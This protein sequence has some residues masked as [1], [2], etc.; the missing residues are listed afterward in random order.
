M[1]ERHGLSLLRCAWPGVEAV[2]ADTAHAFGRH[3]HDQFGIGL[4]ERGAQQSASGRGKVEALAGDLITVN[5]GEVHDGHPLDASG[6]AWRMLYLDPAVLAPLTQDL[7]PHCSFEFSA[8]VL[9]DTRL[10]AGFRA[11]FQTATAS[12]DALRFES[13]LLTLLTGLQAPAERSPM[14]V[15]GGVRRV[16]Q[17]LDDDPGAPWSLGDLA[18]LAGLSRFQLLRAFARWTGLPPHAYLLQRR[19]QLARRLLRRGLPPVEAAAASGFAD[20]SHMTRCLVRSYG[21]TPGSLARA[22]P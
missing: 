1:G 2:A 21:L 18:A 17:L 9:H 15:G 7:A 6:R 13:L 11:L 10:A 14:A 22:S 19:T 20:Q 16:R 5:P 4:I 3:T 8:P 12:A